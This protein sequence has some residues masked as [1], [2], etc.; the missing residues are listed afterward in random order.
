MLAA[1]VPPMGYRTY[2]ILPNSSSVARPKQ[3]DKPILENRFYRIELD[4]ATG[5]I[6]SIRD[7]QLGVELVDRKAPHKFNEYLYERFEKPA[8]ATWSGAAAAELDIARGPVADVATVRSK[9]AGVRSLRQSVILYRDVKRIDFAI[10]MDK[11][12]S[13]RTCRMS[14]RDKRHREA[15]YLA[16]PLTVPQY[17]FHHELPGCVARPVLD[18]FGGACTAYYAVRHFS[19][20]SNARYGVTLSPVESSLVEYGRPRC[21]LMTGPW[22]SEG[23]FEKEMTYPANSRMYLYL[24]NNMFDCN[25]RWDQRGPVRF[26]YSLRSHAGG[27][28]EGKASQFGWEVHNPL[29]ARV[30]RGKQP[31]FL[32]AAGHGFVAI[33]RANVVCTT[34]KPAE[35]NGRGFIFRFVE[36]EGKATTATVSAPFV[37]RIALANETN[38]VESDRPTA[39]GVKDG[40]EVVFS[41]PAFGV[42]TIRVLVAPAAAPVADLR[43]E[44]V[45]D[46]EVSLAWRV[47]ES[48]A[49]SIGHFNVYRG[50]KADFQPTLLNLVAR[51]PK[52]TY[53]DRPALNHG[54]WINNRLEPG[55]TYYYRVAAVDRWN[56]RGPLSPA[57]KATTLPS[58][59]KNVPPLPVE[60]LRAVRVSDLADY[61]YLNLLWRS[62]C[63]ADIVRYEVHRGT[64]PGFTP[65]ESNRVGTVDVDT[66]LPGVRAYGRVP[67]D[68]RLGDYDHQ[69]FADENVEPVK[70]YYYRVC[71]VD[72]AGQRGPFSA[73]V[74]IQTKDLFFRTS[75]QSAFAPRYGPDYAVDGDPDPLRAWVSKPYGGGTKE[76]PLDVWW[77]IEFFKKPIT[78]EGVK[79][80]GD[81]REIIPPQKSLLVQAREAGEWKTVGRAK[82]SAGKDI[83]VRF[84]QPITT[85][86]LRIF[87]ARR[88][89]AALR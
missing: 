86:A 23:K 39:L 44:A 80:I 1:E 79:I 41:I 29:I 89:F 62:N 74:S 77:A 61:G 45:A 59:E 57:V 14:P 3:D 27:W 21:D 16:L 38:L 65:N 75:A 28:Q 2:R 34:I 64:R 51:P 78:I 30:I 26:H 6:A 66:V 22:P 17:E 69:M 19:D 83:T 25:I 55:V 5:T 9:P 53:L 82:A 76:E 85:G 12:P 40:R 56:N 48:S 32:P 72:A 11:S 20:V 43:A 81:H 84:A 13:G 63:E 73:E 70:T 35:A 24:M 15:V 18:L 37:G 60:Q 33:D 46:M 8:S 47:D 50:T 54:G 88:R 49:N 68:H 31:G 4:A 58:S 42:K 67:V 71:A 36:T 52:T 10:E 7:K 87:R